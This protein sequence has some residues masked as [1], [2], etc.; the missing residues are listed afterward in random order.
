MKPKYLRNSVPLGHKNTAFALLDL[1]EKLIDTFDITPDKA[2]QDKMVQEFVLSRSI[3]LVEL[4]K[5]ELR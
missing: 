5:R 4:A 2:K 3:L 1:A